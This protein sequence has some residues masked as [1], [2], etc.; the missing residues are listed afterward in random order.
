MII[1]TKQELEDAKGSVVFSVTYEISSDLDKKSYK[2]LN[3]L[4]AKKIEEILEALPHIPL[5][6]S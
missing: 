3:Q 1:K 6:I 2:K 5:K 4:I